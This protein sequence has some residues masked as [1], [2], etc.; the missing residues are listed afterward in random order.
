MSG[1]VNRVIKHRLNVNP[2]KKPIQQK[3]RVFVL[4]RNKVVM[5][6]I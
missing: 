3:Q 6:E 4:E 5:E 2:T 1:I